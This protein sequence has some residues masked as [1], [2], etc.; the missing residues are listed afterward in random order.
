M[1]ALEL[2]LVLLMVAAGLGV[3]A[4]RLELPYPM[5]LV[6]GGLALAFVPGRPTALID[7]ELVLLIFLPPLLFAAAWFTS[8]RDFAANERPI[9]LLAVG[10][11]VATTSAVA[12]VAHALIPDMSWPV[13]FV[14]GA[15]VSPPDAVAATAV[16]Q[17]LK[18][19]RRIVTIIEGESLVNDAT[20]L[21]A[22]KFALAAVSTGAFSI[23]TAT[24]R[25]AF[26][27]VGGVALGLAVGWLA[28]QIHRHMDHFELETVITLLTPY[29]AYIPA[30]HLGVS[31]VLATVAAGG[32]LGWRN[33]ELLSALTR[34]RGRGVWSVLLLLFNGLVFILIGLQ[35]SA[36]HEI[37]RGVPWLELIT[38]AVAVSGVTILVRLIYVPI[39]TYVPRFLSP[40]L[41]ARDPY[42]P[43]RNVALIA[44][45]GMR[46][47]VSLALALALPMAMPGRPTVIVLS[48][49]VILVTL[50]FQGLS[51]PWL[52]RTLGLTDDG[53]DLR[54]EREALIVAGQAAL[55]RLKEI[56]DTSIIHPQLLERVRLPYDERLERLAEEEREDPECRLTE[57]QGAAFRRIRGEALAAERKAVVEL[58]NRGRISEEVLHRVQEALDLE[59]LQPDR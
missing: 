3:L 13:A 59:A 36:I 7:P 44:W 15:I 38:Y 30:E 17:R 19:P 29:V 54:E 40:S 50:L 48:F 18:V 4:D 24:G 46:G 45:T 20:G 34:Y 39:A 21:V 10:L 56:D 26:V 22:Y 37:S 33:P 8:W 9:A 23:A 42:P 41:R 47:I 51:L 35:L 53:A 11:V 52:I 31:G 2:I 55:S 43:W 27:A 16:T 58:R 14:L 28:A 49:A 57:G 5:L 6:L 25:F 32:Y 1:N 12:W